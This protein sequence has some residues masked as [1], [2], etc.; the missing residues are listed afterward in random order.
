MTTKFHPKDGASV[1]GSHIASFVGALYFDDFIVANKS[2]RR[3]SEKTF[4]HVYK[5]STGLHRAPRE[6]LVSLDGDRLVVGPPAE[7]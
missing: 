1:F 2:I 7:S 6:F 5:E 4:V 3:C